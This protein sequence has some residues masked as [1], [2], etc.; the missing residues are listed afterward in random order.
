MPTPITIEVDYQN[1]EFTPG[2]TISGKVTWQQV[3]GNRQVA[4]RLFWFTSGRGTQDIEVIRELIWPMSEGSADF[5]LVLP[6]EPYSF[7]GTLIS[8]SWALEAV[9]LPS[10]DASERFEF[11][12]TP[13]GRPI[14]LTP[15]E[16]SVTARLKKKGFSVTS[17]N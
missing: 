9:L 8:L 16:N 11:N 15:V 10:E 5:S 2:D 12:L 7:S 17:N 4:L 13:N 6:E 3:D 1:T 14:T